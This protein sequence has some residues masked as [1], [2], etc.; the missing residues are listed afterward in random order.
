MLIKLLV[1]GDSPTFMYHNLQRFGYMSSNSTEEVTSVVSSSTRSSI[2]VDSPSETEREAVVPAKQIP[3]PKELLRPKAEVRRPAPPVPLTRYTTR[4]HF[5]SEGLISK[6]PTT[7]LLLPGTRPTVKEEPKVLPFRPRF[8]TSLALAETTP[9]SARGGV[10]TKRPPPVKPSAK[11]AR[12][13]LFGSKGTG[14]GKARL[15]G[16]VGPIAPPPKRS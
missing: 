11:D 10:L 2:S 1:G 13:G 9:K 8:F 3:T 12:Q 6:V 16:P 5:E 7:F 15:P 4:T 14:K